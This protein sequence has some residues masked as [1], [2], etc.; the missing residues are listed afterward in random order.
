[1]LIVYIKESGP[2]TP[3]KCLQNSKPCRYSMLS[4]TIKF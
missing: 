4:V 3:V 2:K 1:M